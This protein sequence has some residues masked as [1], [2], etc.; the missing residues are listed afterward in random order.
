MALVDRPDATSEPRF[1]PR[2]L[3]KAART[4]R[5]RD[6]ALRTWDRVRQAPKRS[7]AV[8]RGALRSQR[9]LHS[10]E[11]RLVQEALFGLVRRERGLSTLLNTSEPLA[12]WLGWLVL[13]GLEPQTAAEEHKGRWTT[14]VERW[15]A[16]GEGRS[17]TERLAL[18]HSLPDHLARRL[19]R[20]LGTAGA[21]A[22]LEASDQ[23]AP[24]V[25]R[26][27]RLKC[28]RDALSHRLNDEGI[29]TQPSETVEDALHVVGRHN[30]E[31]LAS[32]R[33]GWFEIQDE[34]SQRLAALIEPQ[35]PVVDFCA[36]AGGKS[37][38]IAAM[39]VQVVALDV[40]T[41]ALN[42]LSRR[43]RRAGAEI[44][45]IRIAP[46]G[47]LPAAVASLQVPQV[48]VDAPCTGTGVLRRHPEHRYT[49]DRAFV[50]SRIA[51]QSSIL[52]RASRLVAPQGRLIYGT[53]SVLQEE[54]ERVV[55]GF[56]EHHE[57]WHRGPTLH[58]APHTDGTDGFFGAVLSRET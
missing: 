20:S 17:D 52:D 43:A 42:E 16:L 58:V 36:G 37:L 57:G 32:F 2:L 5:V 12:L 23:R 18:R 6:I 31:G 50:R 49:I 47:P 11:R 55:D 26:A 56:L 27:N 7:G 46:Q 19:V 54:N 10:R 41:P 28:D 45:V 29:A 3:V 48:L 40:R 24:V 13:E 8:L 39:G 51:L 14:L 33:D 44:D 1:D 21:E 4:G 38:A 53:C 30:L 25:L 9:S 35:G 34:G 22:F 15:A